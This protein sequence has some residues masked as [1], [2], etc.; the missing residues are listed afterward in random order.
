MIFLLPADSYG[1]LRDKMEIGIT[2]IHKERLSF[3]A[4]L[5]PKTM[6]ISNQ[7]KRFDK[8]IANKSFN[9]TAT[10]PSRAM[11]KKYDIIESITDNRHV[12]TINPLETNS[13]KVIIYLHGGAYV[14]NL[15][16][17]HWDLIDELIVKTNASFVVP[18]YPLAP[19]F[20]YKE[21]YEFLINLYNEISEQTSPQNI[22][23]IGDS[24]GG[25]LALGFSMYLRN[26][27]I[28]LPSKL[29]LLSP[30]LDI[31]MSNPDILTKDKKDKILGIKGLEMAA[32]YYAGDTELTHYKLSPLYGDLSGLPE[33]TVFTA[34]HDLCHPDILKLKQKMDG[35]NIPVNYFEYPKLF[36]AWVII[37]NLR[38]A[39]HAIGQ[40]SE[41]ILH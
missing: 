7:K 33:I 34:T 3:T 17:Y 19:E 12:W 15:T 27:N 10:A 23:F 1:A 16:K 28:S 41:I 22:I 21:V 11:K 39:K 36:H 18:D 37:T 9:Q 31:S 25:G 8:D 14:Y 24:A 38:E 30:W 40:M 29:I 6:A 13:D 20:T 35:Q 5:I 2:Y 32:G 4:R 26:N